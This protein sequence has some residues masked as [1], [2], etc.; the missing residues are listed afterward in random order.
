[1][2]ASDLGLGP[3]ARSSAGRR[4]AARL[5]GTTIYLGPCRRWQ[6]VF[7]VQL[8]ALH[9]DDEDDLGA[10]DDLDSRD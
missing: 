8:D 7:Q 9:D 4:A 2:Y 10:F 5:G 1:M 6:L 3:R